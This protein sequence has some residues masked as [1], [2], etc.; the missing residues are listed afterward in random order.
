MFLAYTEAIFGAGT[1]VRWAIG[2]P[3]VVALLLSVL[4]AL[5][6]CG[7]SLYQVAH[8]GLL[9]RFFGQTN[10]HGVPAHAM[11]FN[12]VCSIV[13]V[14]FGSPLEIYIFSNM[15]YLL[16]VCLTLF[17]YFLYR[18]RHPTVS[19]PV[20]M[21]GFLRFIALHALEGRHDSLKESVIGVEVFDRRPGYDPKL[22]PIVRIQAR[23]LRAKLEDYYRTAGAADAVRGTPCPGR[24]RRSRSA[25]HRRR[26]GCAAR[27]PPA[28]ARS[29]PRTAPSP[30]A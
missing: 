9:P 27:R 6:G 4:N 10:R 8:D 15:G 11:A 19:R 1:W 14:F 20:R 5:M 13:V 12:L 21:P 26:S 29:P 30:A 24:P 25:R 23:R 18:Q 2:I 28:P 7:R 3:L 16:S 22:E 17:G